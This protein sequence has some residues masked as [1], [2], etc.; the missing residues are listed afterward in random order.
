MGLYLRC[1]P[2][3]PGRLFSNKSRQL[4]QILVTSFIVAELS[5]NPNF[6][7][8]T[9]TLSE[10][11]I[12]TLFKQEMQSAITV[13]VIF[14]ACADDN[15]YLRLSDGKQVSP[16]T[17]LLTRLQRKQKLNVGDIISIKEVC[18]EPC[19]DIGDENVLEDAGLH[20]LY[21]TK[22]SLIERG[23]SVGRVIGAASLRRLDSYRD[24]IVHVYPALVGPDKRD[25]TFFSDMRWDPKRSKKLQDDRDQCREKGNYF[26]KL[27][28]YDLAVTFYHLAIK[29]DPYDSRAWANISQAHFK[30]DEYAEAEKFALLA[31]KMDPFN[32]KAYYRAAKA[33][34]QQSK[35]AVTVAYSQN[36]IFLCSNRKD[37][38]KLL[39]EAKFSATSDAYVQI[40]S[41]LISN[42]GK[43]PTKLQG[44]ITSTL[45]TAVHMGIMQH[46]D[47]IINNLGLLAFDEN[48]PRESKKTKEKWENPG[49]LIKKVQEENKKKEEDKKRLEE[50]K[51]KEQEEEKKKR[52][53]EV[54]K[55]MPVVTAKTRNDYNDMLLEGRRLFESELVHQAME[56]FIKCLAQYNPETSKNSNQKNSGGEHPEV[57]NLQFIIGKCKVKASRGSLMEGIE[58]LKLLCEKTSKYPYKAAVHCLLATTFMKINLYKLAHEHANNC[59]G[60]IKKE[61]H[62]K[63]VKWPG[64]NEPISSTKPEILEE[65]CNELLSKPSSSRPSSE[66]LCRFKDCLTTQGH[67]YAKEDIYLSDPD[68]RGYIAVLC[69]EKCTI[70][71]HPCCWKA[72]KEQ[73]EIFIG[74]KPDKEFLGLDCMTPDCTGNISSIRIYDESGTLK[75]EQVKD[76]KDKLASLPIKMKKKKEKKKDK[77]L[78]GKS[79]E[80]KKNRI[81]SVHEESPTPDE[82][83]GTDVATRNNANRKTNQRASK[84]PVAIA[85]LPIDPESLDPTQVTVIKPSSAVEEENTMQPKKTRKKNKK[86]KTTATL[87]LDPLLLH[88]NVQ[89]D[90]VAR[91]RSL[92]EQKEA[93][94]GGVATNLLA[95]DPGSPN[96][97]AALQLD[98]SNP[99]YL[100]QHLRDNPEELE[101]VLQKKI[102]ISNTGLKQDTIDTLLEFMHE[103]LKSEGPMSIHDTR[104]KEQVSENFPPEAQKYVTQCGGIRG[105]LMQ[106]LKFAM[107]DDVICASCDVVCAQETTCTEVKTKMN[108]ARYLTKFSD[109]VQ[110]KTFIHLLDDKST[111]S[112][113]SSNSQ[114]AGSALLSSVSKNSSESTHSSSILPHTSSVSAPNMREDREKNLVGESPEHKPSVVTEADNESLLE[115]NPKAR[116][117]EPRISFSEDTMENCELKEINDTNGDYEDEDID[118]EEEE[119]EEKYSE[120]NDE[121]EQVNSDGEDIFHSDDEEDMEYIEQLNTEVADLQEKL[122]HLQ[123]EKQVLYDKLCQARSQ[124]KSEIM[125]YRQKCEELEQ[126]LKNVTQEK[127][128]LSAQRENEARKMKNDMARMTEEVRTSQSRYQSLEL[129]WERSNDRVN[130]LTAKL[131]EEEEHNLE[132]EEETKDLRESLSSSSRRA[133]EAE[134]KY[135]C[136]KK[137]LV[138][139]S[140]ARTVERLKEEGARM[141]QLLESAT[142]DTQ[143]D[144]DTLTRTIVAWEETIKALLDQKKA[145]TDESVKLLGIVNQGRPL[146]A[147][148]PGD[149]K[150][151]AVPNFSVAPLLCIM[152]NPRESSAR[153]PSDIM[154]ER[155][156][157]PSPAPPPQSSN[158]EPPQVHPQST[159][160]TAFPLEPQLAGIPLMYQTPPLLPNSGGYAS[161]GTPPLVTSAPAT[162]AF[163]TPMAFPTGAIPK[164]PP[165]LQ[166]TRTAEVSSPS[167]WPDD[168]QLFVGQLPWGYTETDLKNVFSQL[169]GEVVHASVFDQGRNAEGKQVPMFGF[170]TFRNASDCAKVLEKRP[171]IINNHQ[172]NIQPREGKKNTKTPTSN[173]GAGGGEVGVGIGGMGGE[174][175]GSETVARGLGSNSAYGLSDISLTLDLDLNSPSANLTHRPRPQAPVATPI[176]ANASVN[177]IIRPNFKNLTSTNSGGPTVTLPPKLSR[178]QPKHA[179]VPTKLGNPVALAK[180]DSVANTPSYKRLIEICKQRLGK[181]FS[182]PDI[183]AALR[184]VRA[185]NNNSLSGITQEKIVERVRSTLKSRRPGA[186]QATVAPWA[187]L[188]HGGGAGAAG[189]E[190]QGPR[191]EEGTAKEESCSICLDALSTSPSMSLSCQHVFHERCIKGWLKRQSNCPNCRRFSLMADEYPK[192]T[193]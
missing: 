126:E 92:K 105:F 189:S 127:H 170:V 165:N 108:A 137:D 22:C 125:R 65:K 13:Q 178:P 26:F 156:Q 150:I 133:H 95:T 5:D 190:W 59:C 30:M 35:S 158:T 184:E 152:Q 36:G 138:E 167:Q 187:G 174:G 73:Q 85:P 140:L 123:E 116:E 38:Y 27:Q 122:D 88:Q 77:N 185:M 55:E 162:A 54:K 182:S 107:I 155:I 171:I 21:I 139:E 60:I 72:Y 154:Q 100:P 46:N 45:H 159:P 67:P 62:I 161:N 109:G 113:A 132:L 149:L 147:L 4:D 41:H 90:Y 69:E 106:S 17:F 120:G 148:P 151:P 10:E 50:E 52:K 63:P 169:F 49:K 11:G 25:D 76:K 111:C 20:H 160:T 101:R 141:E 83:S 61:K 176:T 145:F 86:V 118:D 135:L 31:I 70:C 96:P 9:T 98:P 47:E 102:Q 164:G 8:T 40:K 143:P 144:R 6:N 131:V 58:M 173:G 87:D 115:L 29:R 186:G 157:Q 89:N 181:D 84:P 168:H 16:I 103:W 136:I 104:L 192:L 121:N 19:R 3:H 177:T 124:S 119:G 188:V 193:H 39:E 12:L 166:Q 153:S 180:E 53:Q 1:Q 110:A 32:D 191:R 179:Q 57:Q 14:I 97:L 66:A 34:Q 142:N 56:M 94:E 134:V 172:L 75:N 74:K 64:T 79:G 82:T 37:L 78:G 81:E 42:I 112:S 99:F 43:L 2:G 130:E 44:N 114:L 24:A 91:L 117:F 163:P 51:R 7:M 18:L 128:S 80:K 183:C 71:Y 93:L 146:N 68:F 33:A 48:I 15:C 23:V 129:K 28:K 175:G